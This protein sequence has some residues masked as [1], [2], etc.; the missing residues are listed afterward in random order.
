MR[1][2]DGTQALTPRPRRT[3][4]EGAG[5]DR[6]KA[7]MAKLIYS[8]TMSLDGYIAGPGG[9]M[10]WMSDLPVEAD[11]RVV[12]RLLRGIGALLVGNTSH[13]GDDPNRGTDAEGAFG[14][15]YDGPVVVL[16]HHPPAVPEPGV[17]FSNELHEAIGLAKAAAGEHEYV[18]IIGADVA[19]QCREAGELD[20][21]LLFI[22]P[23]LL[24]DGTRAFPGASDR[25]TRLEPLPGVDAHWYRVERA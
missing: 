9:D 17:V 11:D 1:A 13:R 20:E 18:N 4:L 19:R 16:A 23:V 21:I 25:A 7:L 24:G 12:D 10:S 5:S 14:G 2:A 15:R 3:R 22:A 6:R 8:A